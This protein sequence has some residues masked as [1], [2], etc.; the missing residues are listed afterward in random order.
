M[1][2]REDYSGLS[3]EEL[4]DKLVET[5]EEMD[6]LRI[7]KATHQLTN[8]LR[9]REVRREIARLK[10]FIRQHEL[11]INVAKSEQA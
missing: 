6:N 1:K 7:Q 2:N 4:K 9:I 3:L 5:V 11:N 8:P 10:T